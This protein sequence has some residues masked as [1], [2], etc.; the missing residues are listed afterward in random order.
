MVQYLV[1][2]DFLG[3]YDGLEYVSGLGYQIDI[4]GFVSYPDL[5]ISQIFDPPIYGYIVKIYGIGSAEKYHR[6]LSNFLVF[7]STKLSLRTCLLGVSHSPIAHT[8]FTSTP[9]FEGR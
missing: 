5:N 6:I 7:L 1:D 9:P 3:I 4:T 2:A 8:F